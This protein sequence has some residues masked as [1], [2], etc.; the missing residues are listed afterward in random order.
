M[1]TSIKKSTYGWLVLFGLTMALGPLAAL[2]LGSRFAGPETLA[3]AQSGAAN[4][5]PSDLYA[6][7][8]VEATP[9]SASNTTLADIIQNSGTFDSFSTAIG[10][11]GLNDYLTGSRNYTLFVPSDEAFANMSASDRDALLADEG[12]LVAL[13]NKHSVPGRLSKADLARGDMQVQAM[14]GSM[15][16]VGPTA[17]FNGHVGVANAQ[18]VWTD[19]HASNGVV[20][21][22]D[23]VIQ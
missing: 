14:D 9:A 20:H 23:R 12:A 17:D 7:Y 10:L 5:E 15:L 13:V 11:A 18:V 21:V 4:A 22:I 8:D 6:L 16:K 19:L 1:S 2:S 3:R